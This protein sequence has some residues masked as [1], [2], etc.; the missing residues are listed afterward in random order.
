[1]GAPDAIK[2]SEIAANKTEWNIF[3]IELLLSKPWASNAKVRLR[4][5]W[6]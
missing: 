5:I 1:M 6:R 3:F 4:K 2:G